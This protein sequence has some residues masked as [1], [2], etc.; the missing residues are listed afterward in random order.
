MRRLQ[1]G[2][3]PQAGLRRNR[4][5]VSVHT[6]RIIPCGL[7]ISE[8]ASTQVTAEV[9]KLKS[10]SLPVDHGRRFKCFKANVRFK[11][12]LR[13]GRLQGSFAFMSS[14][15]AERACVLKSKGRSSSA[16]G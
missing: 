8:V 15:Q 2:V 14:N 13:K 5:R 12:A 1:D 7:K 16:A 9:E 3:R 6:H 10:G 4:R 11:E